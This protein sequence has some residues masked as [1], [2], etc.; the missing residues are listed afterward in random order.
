[1]N[2]SIKL[3]AFFFCLVPVVM[4]CVR[5]SDSSSA[6]RPLPIDPVH[7]VTKSAS[8]GQA[9][10]NL[11]PLILAEIGAFVLIIDAM[12]RRYPSRR[13]LAIALAVLGPLTMGITSAVYYLRWGWYMVELAADEGSGLCAECRANS[14]DQGLPSMLAQKRIGCQM[15]GGGNR[16]QSCS[17]TRGTIWLFTLF[18][19][20]PIATYRFL[21][22]DDDDSGLSEG[23][24]IFRKTKFDLRQAILVYA[25]D[26]AVIAIFVLMLRY[27]I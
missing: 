12:M 21:R 5:L 11:G 25:V 8:A 20:V 22:I 10:A 26:A 15:I 16:C 14:F 2:T 4:T 23:S 17:S 13:K 9:I 19:L 3:V 27:Y 18:P 1:M 6:G 7:L 24:G